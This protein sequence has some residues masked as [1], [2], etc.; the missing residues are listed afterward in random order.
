MPRPQ[1]EGALG[2]LRVFANNV[3]R[4]VELANAILGFLP[5]FLVGVSD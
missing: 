3:E 5:R 2:V 4:Q 1:T